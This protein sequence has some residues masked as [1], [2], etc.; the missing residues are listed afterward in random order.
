MVEHGCGP[1]KVAR[2]FHR[3]FHHLAQ[4]GC[5][6]WPLL[7]H[8]QVYHRKP[9]RGLSSILNDVHQSSIICSR[10]LNAAMQAL[11]ASP[12]I[13]IRCTHIGSKPL[14]TN[15]GFICVQV[16][17][18]LGFL[19]QELLN[20]HSGL[21]LSG[22]LIILLFISSHRK[23]GLRFGCLLRL[24]LL[25]LALHLGRDFIT[26]RLLCGLFL[27]FLFFLDLFFRFGGSFGVGGIHV[28]LQAFV[29]VANRF[30]LIY[31]S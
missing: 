16:S 30:F 22:F 10:I 4:L 9:G 18:R 23:S 13:H 11:G 28:A 31:E 29:F 25:H 15:T 6:L 24:V 5:S 7:V 27:R 1:S 14:I 21:A 17:K 2:S 26:L 3:I 19:Y 8:W 12:Q 20:A